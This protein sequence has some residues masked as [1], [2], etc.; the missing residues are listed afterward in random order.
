MA[1]R[2]LELLFQSALPT[3]ATK[4]DAL[5]VFVHWKLISKGFLCVGLGNEQALRPNED[6]TELLPANWNES[7]EVYALHY[8]KDDKLYLMNA[9]L[10]DGQLII[11]IAT[12]DDE[13][14]SFIALECATLI[15]DNLAVFKE[16]F[17]DSDALDRHL[18]KKLMQSILVE[19]KEEA[20]STK[21]NHPRSP[22]DHVM[23]GQPQNPPTRRGE[24]FGP[25]G[26][27]PAYGEGD[28]H[29]G[30]RGGMIMDARQL[31]N[32]GRNPLE[33]R[34]NPAG[35]RFDPIFPFPTKAFDP[36]KPPG[37]PGNR[38]DPDNLLPPK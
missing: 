13:H 26:L 23:V 11:K 8:S 21:V 12:I 17:V 2:G 27:L 15:G 24:G 36:R 20:A 31:I 5:V 3:I 34:G 30:G 35:A 25:I 10:I 4:Q 1:P 38:P 33:P 22:I 32:P 6:G 29:I 37:H 19:K 28:L 18:E 14:C 7:H 9:V 16:V